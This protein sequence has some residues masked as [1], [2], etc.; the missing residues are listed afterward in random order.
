MAGS[1]CVRLSDYMRQK[2]IFLYYSDNELDTLMGAKK[3]V[4]RAKPDTKIHK[5]M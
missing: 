4:K 2:K 1:L 3:S 5:T